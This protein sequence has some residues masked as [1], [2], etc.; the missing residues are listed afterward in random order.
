MA[1]YEELAHLDL[2][3]AEGKQ[4]VY[5]LSSRI[6]NNAEGAE[7]VSRQLLSTMRDSLA[8]L[9]QHREIVKRELGEATTTSRPAARRDVKTPVAD[10]TVAKR[11]SNSASG[12]P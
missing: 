8:L 12:T 6:E 2:A 11:R 1:S 4:R 5:R 3:I 7:K 10:H 9:I